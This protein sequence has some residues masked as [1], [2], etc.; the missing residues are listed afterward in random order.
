[1]TDNRREWYPVMGLVRY[2]LALGVV[3]CHVIILCGY[4]L[5]SLNLSF[6][7][8]GGFF[9]ISGFLM[10][11]DYMKHH[12]AGTY[13]K[14][15]ARR[16]LPAYIFIVLLCAL[17]LWTVSS[18]SI[19]AYFADAQLYKYLLWNLC[20]LNWLEPGL[21][22][23][24]TSP[25]HLFTAVNGSL[26]TMKVEWCLYLSMPVFVWIC[27]KI[28]IGH[29]TAAVAIIAFSILYRAF[30]MALYLKTGNELYN[31]LGR[32]I[33]GMLSFFYCGVIFYFYRRWIARHLTPVIVVGMI[34]ILLATVNR[35]AGYILHPIGIT[36]VV[37]G[38]SMT[39][40]NLRIGSS[41]M[42]VSYEIYLFHWPVI[43]LLV[44]V[45]KT[46]SPIGGLAISIACSA[47]FATGYHFFE[48]YV[49]K[50]HII[51]A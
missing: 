36:A 38:L 19:A 30:A 18:E 37:I 49:I 50:P 17:T 45:I 48:K 20:F 29:A 3:Y 47:L 25:D 5:P 31:I 2:A 51:R 32:Q 34:L 7:S 28:R 43:Q 14:R 44:P 33:F 12:R 9:S 8:V 6:Y 10:Y 13:V 39:A 4:D 24:F 21:P 23:V 46:W 41:K 27:R 15:R 11:P 42:N 26:W 40:R 35:V 1:M 22:G 16:I